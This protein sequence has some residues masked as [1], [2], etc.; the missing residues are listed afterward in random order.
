MATSQYALYAIYLESGGDA[1][2][3]GP[4]SRFYTPSARSEHADVRDLI[5][6][7]LFRAPQGVLD[8]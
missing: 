2:E 8:D 6:A 7:N 5:R 4:Q 3:N 1:P